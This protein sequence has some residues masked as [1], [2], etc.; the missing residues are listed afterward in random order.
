MMEKTGSSVFLESVDYLTGNNCMLI[1]GC[2]GDIP[3]IKGVNPPADSNGK[4][5][6]TTKWVRDLLVSLG[7]S[8]AATALSDD[9]ESEGSV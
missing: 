2:N 6:A 1:L 8:G 7:M 9:T 3:Y 4:D 5:V